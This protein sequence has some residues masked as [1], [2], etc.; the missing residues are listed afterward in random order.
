MQSTNENREHKAGWRPHEHDN[1]HQEHKLDDGEGMHLPHVDMRVGPL[2]GVFGLVCA[3]SAAVVR[4]SRYWGQEAPRS[5][6]CRAAQKYWARS[7]HRTEQNI[8]HHITGHNIT[9][10]TCDEQPDTVPELVA[11]QVGPSIVQENA[12]QNGKRDAPQSWAQEQ[13]GQQNQQMG[14]DT[15][16]TLFQATN[17]LCARRQ[18]QRLHDSCSL[19]VHSTEEL[20]MASVGVLQPRRCS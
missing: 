11:C 5:L 9:P 17:D 13:Q 7:N 18:V 3:S 4:D 15:G 2:L 1:G 10:P 6:E 19:L 20:C 14:R 8:S 12:P 16:H